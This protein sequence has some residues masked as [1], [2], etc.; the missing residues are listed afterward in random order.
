MGKESTLVHFPLEASTMS[1][2]S[3]LQVFVKALVNRT[4]PEKYQNIIV[5][6]FPQVEDTYKILN[7]PYELHKQIEEVVSG[8]QAILEEDTKQGYGEKKQE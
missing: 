4:I 5:K 8:L 1:Q 2:F 6:I 7:D 3:P